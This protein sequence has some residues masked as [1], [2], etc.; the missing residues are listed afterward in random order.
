MAKTVIIGV[1]GNQGYAPDQINTRMTLGAMIEELQ[2]AAEQFGEDAL[3]VTAD[4]Q[5]RYGANFGGFQSYAG[6]L[7][8]SDAEPDEDE[9]GDDFKY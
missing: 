8:I 6:N 4:N 5:N 9:Y 7:A 1:N 3:V 2:E